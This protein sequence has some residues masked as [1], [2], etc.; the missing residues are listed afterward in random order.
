V[1]I[2]LAS[3]AYRRSEGLPYETLV[4]L[5]A[6]QATLPGRQFQLVSTPGFDVITRLATGPIRGLYQADGVL[7]GRAFVVAGTKLYTLTEAGVSVE[8]GTIGGSD[9][10][11]F[12][13]SETQLAICAAGKGYVAD[14][15]SVAIITDPDF[16]SNVV[17]V[18]YAGGYFVWTQGGTGRKNYSSV[19]DATAYDGLDFVTAEAKPD[20]TRALYYDNGQLLAFGSESIQP[21]GISG[22]PDAAFV[23]YPASVV[24]RGIAARDASAQLDNT[25]F[26]VGDDRIVYRLEGLS[27]RRIS[28]HAIEEMLTRVSE[29]SLPN[30]NGWAYA[31]DGHTFF[32]VDIP[33]EGTFVYDVATSRWHERRSWGEAYYRPRV[34]RRMWGKVVAG[35]RVDGAIYALNPLTASQDQTAVEREW[36]AGIPV[37]EGRPALYKLSLDL[38]AGIGSLAV[39]DPQIMMQYS[40]DLGRT[41]STERIRQMGRVA[42]YDFQ[43]NWRRLGRMEPLGR[44]IRFRTTDLVSY[45]VLGVR[46]N[47]RKP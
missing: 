29:S 42:D 8:I 13:A 40:D 47:V 10:V 1:L 11:R 38:S 14:A 26:F 41:W 3:R 23:P 46:A 18:A 36:T 33:G 30:L 24:E 32:G 43:L 17:D 25:I 28:D 27:P 31:Q 2:P 39:P 12:A 5:F 19:L 7:G 34:M 6:E 16:P 20:A 37:N 35:S 44:M 9:R 4:N 15:S 45:T 22:D 21:F